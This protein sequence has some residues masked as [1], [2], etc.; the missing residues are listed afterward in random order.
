M[1]LPKRQR[2]KLAEDLWFS[3]A[4][5]SLPVRARDRRML[6]ERWTAYQEGRAKRLSLLE[7]ERRLARK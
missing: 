1:K 7:L 4:D 5:D 2:L 6:D 3:G